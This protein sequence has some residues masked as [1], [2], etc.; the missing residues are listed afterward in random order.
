MTTQAPTNGTHR[1]APKGPQ[2]LL[3][4]ELEKVK[5]AMAQVLPKHVTPERMIKVVLSAT[6][7]QPK[8][9]ECTTASI[10]RSVMQAA[11]LGLEIGGLLGE[12]YLVPYNNKIKG[13]RGEP[14]RWENQAQCI[15]GYRGLIK[16]ARQSGE[17]ATVNARIVFAGDT[18][19]VDLAQDTISHVPNFEGHRDDGSIR[20]VYAIIRF[21]DGDAI[22]FDVM[23]KAEVDRIRSRSKSKDVGPWVNDYAEM[24]RKTVTRRALKY[25]PISAERMKRA[26]ELDDED[27]N[28]IVTTGETI[29]VDAIVPAADPVPQTVA[30]LE[31]H[32]RGQSAQ[33]HLDSS[34]AREPVPV[35]VQATAQPAAASTA[36]A[37]STATSSPTTSSTA[38][39]T[40]SERSPATCVVCK[41][42]IGFTDAATATVGGYRHNGCNAVTGASDGN[43]AWGPTSNEREPGVD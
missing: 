31:E 37:S 26:M 18:F 24:A 39:A 16:L 12:A 3:R 42:P 2:Q 34:P 10:V 4:D 35:T 30:A 40:P 7:R 21:H 5:A 32:L 13:E 36:Q 1:Q 17:I 28:A 43:A 38:T 15:P 33:E 20:L 8:L 41:K 19:T 23:T 29:G 6:A 9:L 25:A 27:D 14:D 11:E 22:Q